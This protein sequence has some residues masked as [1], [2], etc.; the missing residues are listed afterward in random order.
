MSNLNNFRVSLQKACMDFA[1]NARP[2]ATYIPPMHKHFKYK[3]WSIVV[4]QQFDYLIMLLIVL[5]TVLLMMKVN[6]DF[7]PHTH[8]TPPC[9]KSIY[10]CFTGF[11]L[12]TVQQ[13]ILIQL[14]YGRTSFVMDVVVVLPIFFLLFSSFVFFFLKRMH[15][16]SVGMPA[17]FDLQQLMFVMNAHNSWQIPTAED[18]TTMAV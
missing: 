16:S 17:M 12:L 18:K 1:I 13:L 11:A 8:T 15:R 6:Y 10:Y 3:V 4:S 2:F 14:L 5:N 7:T 9:V